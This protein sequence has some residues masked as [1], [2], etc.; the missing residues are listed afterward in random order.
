MR[1]IGW[2][3][4]MAGLVLTLGPSLLVFAGRLPWN[5]HAHAMLLGMVLWFIGAALGMRSR[6]RAAEEE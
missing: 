1:I 5:R 6:S 4:A 2:L 3:I